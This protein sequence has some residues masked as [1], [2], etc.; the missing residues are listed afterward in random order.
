MTRRGI[1]L[2]LAFILVC[3]VAALLVKFGSEHVVSSHE[4]DE[5][6]KM[7]QSYPMLFRALDQYVES[8]GRCPPSLTNL[9]LQNFPLNLDEFHYACSNGVCSIR[10]TGKYVNYY[11][12]RNYS[13]I[14]KK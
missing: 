13:D 7:L 9:H 6:I 11:N 12:T 8:N 10:F 5:A 14:L 4:H 1:Y 2:L 3:P